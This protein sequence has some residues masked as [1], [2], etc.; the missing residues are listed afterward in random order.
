MRT[1]TRFLPTCSRRTRQA[2]TSPTGTR[3]RTYLFTK[4]YL[5]AKTMQESIQQI[6][7]T[8]G[9]DVWIDPY[10]KFQYRSPSNSGTAPFAVSDD[11]DFITSFP[12]A[13]TNYEKDDTAIINRVYFYGGKTPSNDYTQDLSQQANGSN[14]TFVLAYYPRPSAEYSITTTDAQGYTTTTQIVYFTVNGEYYPLGTPFVGA[15]LQTPYQ[16]RRHRLRD[17][18]LVLPRPSPS[19]RH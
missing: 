15:P 13:I 18:E 2:L 14:N 8:V 17:P 9:F 4:I 5:R 12:L 3:S 10:K 19:T 16:P 11:P 6:A 7:D 1:T